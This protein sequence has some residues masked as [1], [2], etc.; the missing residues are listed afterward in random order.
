[1]KH[2]GSFC[3]THSLTR[4]ESLSASSAVYSANQSAESRFN[5]PPR[6]YSAS[7]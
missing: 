4:S 5:Q 6:L 3:V 7:G 2:W 1:M